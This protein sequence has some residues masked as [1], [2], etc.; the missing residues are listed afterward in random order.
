MRLGNATASRSRLANGI[1]NRKQEK[2]VPA[3]LRLW[4]CTDMPTPAEAIAAELRRV[5]PAVRDKPFVPLVN[6][7]QDFEPFEI[8]DEF[9]YK[10]D[11][12]KLEAEWL[13]HVPSGMGTAM[14]FLSDEAICFYLPAFLQADLERRL[15]CI[16]PTFCLCRGFE[17]S[18]RETWTNYGRARWARLSKEQAAAIAHY[19]EWRVERDGPDLEYRCIEA[20]KNYW[21]ERA[22]GQGQT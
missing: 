5:F 21:Y 14:I 16:D 13:D 22:S 3:L 17:D 4:Q 10:E 15:K 11:W 18:S 8:A 19:L 1:D 9:R 12:T 6:S 20:L 7:T 2:V